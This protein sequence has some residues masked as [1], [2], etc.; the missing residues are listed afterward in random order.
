[1][2]DRAWQCLIKYV[3]EP[4]HET[5]FHARSYGV[6]SEKRAHDAQKMMFLHLSSRKNNINK[7]ILKLDIVKCFDRIS[8]EAILNK[9]IA[10]NFLIKGLQRCLKAGVNPEFPYQGGVCSPLLANIALNGIEKIGE[11]RKGR[12]TH[13]ICV[14]YAD[15]TVF[16]LKPKNNAE[17]LHVEI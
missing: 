5:T 14:R 13:S 16:V 3:L 17:K 4:V 2:A 9:V 7:R 1:M 8:Y 12:K 15:D 6:R 11:V 10:L